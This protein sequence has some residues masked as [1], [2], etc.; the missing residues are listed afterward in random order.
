MMCSD[1]VLDAETI[2]TLYCRRTRIETLFDAL[3]N[4]MGAFRFHFW[5]RYLPR[6]SR[7]PTANRHLK[8]PQAQ[9]LP[10]VVACWQAMETFVLCAC[11]AG[12]N[13]SAVNLMP[14]QRCFANNASIAGFP[15]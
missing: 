5:S 2:L 14:P 3:K 10:T 4:T 11:I 12:V 8:A 7:R 15:A 13:K 1:L 6:H 9:H